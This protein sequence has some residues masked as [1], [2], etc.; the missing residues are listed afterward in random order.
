[1]GASGYG[2]AF[3]LVLPGERIRGLV[4]TALA[5]FVG[6]A[7]AYPAVGRLS[8]DGTAYR[9]GSLSIPVV[10]AAVSLSA[11]RLVVG[12][13]WPVR[14]ALLAVG[15]APPPD[16]ILRTGVEPSGSAVALARVRTGIGALVALLAAAGLVDWTF[17]Q[18]WARTG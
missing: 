10:R 3:L 12:A 9:A 14:R 1:L 5:A 17:R 13:A 6:F 16:P 4:G 2:L 11:E 7:A 18:F 15:S 8:V